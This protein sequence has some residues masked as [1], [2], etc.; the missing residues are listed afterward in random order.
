M[1]PHSAAAPCRPP[2]PP[3]APRRPPG[4]APAA[5]PLSG[6]F[7]ESPLVL[8][9][10]FVRASRAIRSPP[11]CGITPP[12]TPWRA[13][14]GLPPSVFLTRCMSQRASL[15]PKSDRMPSSSHEYLTRVASGSGGTTA[16][17]LVHRTSSPRALD[18]ITTYP[19]P[20]SARASWTYA[21][22]SDV[23]AVGL[24]E[25]GD[26][27]EGIG[28]VVDDSGDGSCLRPLV[29]P[30][31]LKS[32]RAFSWALALEGEGSSLEAPVEVWVP[33]DG[34]WGAV[35]LPDEGSESPKSGSGPSDD[36]FLSRAT[37]H[38]ASRAGHQS[39]ALPLDG[40]QRTSFSLERVIPT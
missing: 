10:G 22:G 2:S 28:G 29:K 33:C 21:T 17:S 16:S 19:C 13:R 1:A 37:V 34:E 40:S 18:R 5:I 9:P 8:T 38:A 36:G 11:R 35:G 26:G 20:P 30:S 39:T 6:A 15:N 32:C 14:G 24:E 3:L 7:S 12:V 25:L 23:G 4:A 31:F 27:V